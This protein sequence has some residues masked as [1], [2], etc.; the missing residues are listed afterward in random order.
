MPRLSHSL[1]NLYI[2]RDSIPTFKPTQCVSL[3]FHNTSDI[4]TTRCILRKYAT[5][6]ITSDVTNSKVLGRGGG[7]FDLGE[8]K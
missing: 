1:V 4:V 8:T 2:R 6:W 7:C 3:R 5:F